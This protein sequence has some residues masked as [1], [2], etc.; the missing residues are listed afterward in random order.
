MQSMASYHPVQG[1]N[2]AYLQKLLIVIAKYFLMFIVYPIYFSTPN[3]WKNVYVMY[4]FATTQCSKYLNDKK[5]SLQ[6]S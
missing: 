1:I 3:I 5:V 4:I 2:H 6:F